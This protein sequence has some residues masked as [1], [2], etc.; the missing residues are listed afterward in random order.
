MSKGEQKN[1]LNVKERR[2]MLQVTS[3]V[4]NSCRNDGTGSH[5]H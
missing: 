3:V 1:R 5:L 4:L 2:G